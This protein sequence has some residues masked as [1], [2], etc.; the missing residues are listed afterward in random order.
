MPEEIDCQC[1]NEIV[2]PYCG[3]VYKDSWEIFFNSGDS[4]GLECRE[5]ELEFDAERYV[6]VT[7]NTS[8]V[9]DRNGRG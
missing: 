6:S 2:C 3:H 1:T 8:K 9:E 7:Y 5:C 4:A